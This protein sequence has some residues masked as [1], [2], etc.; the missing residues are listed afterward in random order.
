[1]TWNLY[2][3][4]KAHFKLNFFLMG[5]ISCYVHAVEVT[6]MLKKEDVH[7][8]AL[9]KFHWLTHN[10]IEMQSFAHLL[11]SFKFGDKLI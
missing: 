5:G 7:A 1:M 8:L 9:N 4:W 3:F 6:L 2:Y 11:P 10:D